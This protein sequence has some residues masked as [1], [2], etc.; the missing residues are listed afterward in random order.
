VRF[1]D[2]L[3]RR[4]SA[5]LRLQAAEAKYR[6]LVEQL[7]LVT[8][9]DALTASATSL[10]AS[11]QVEPLLGYTVDEWL[12]DPEFFPKLLHPGDRD[13]ILDLVAHCNETADPFRAEYRLIARDGRT[14]WVQDESLVVMDEQGRALFTQGYLLDITARKESEQRFA[15]EHAVARAVAESTT[16]DEAAAR[17][18][19]IVCD[20]VG[21][22]SGEVWLLDREQGLLSSASVEGARATGL[23]ELSRARRA[24]T[25][26]AV[27]VYAVPVTLGQTVLGVLEFSSPGLREPDEDLGGTLGVIAS[28]FAQFIERKRSE[29]ALRHQA[30]HDALTGLPNRTLFHDRFRQALELARRGGQPLALLVMDLDSFKDVNDTLGHQCGDALLKQ[31]GRRLQDGV[32]AC[33]TV[34]RLGGDEFGFLLTD[35]DSFGTAAL[36]QRIQATLADPFLVEDRF[37]PVEASM[38]VALHPEH[39]ED[40][41]KLLQRADVAMYTAKR[42]G[43]GCAFYEAGKDQPHDDTAPLSR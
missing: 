30:L 26:D 15:A 35:V 9:I 21:W 37:L 23:A 42:T 43:I 3:L 14:V 4:T 1:L 22:E 8:Y 41:D 7:P 2:R 28:Q 6:T 36:I 34:A 39:G 20:T 5:E 32:R 25:W 10:Y 13:R 24:P 12:T 33:D 31:V 18:V 16:L 29:E 17:I 27:G 40:V 38:G 19:R 11:P